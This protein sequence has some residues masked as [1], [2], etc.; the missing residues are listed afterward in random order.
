MSEQTY[1]LTIL[2]IAKIA[3]MDRIASGY[4]A[5]LANQ[6]ASFTRTLLT[7]QAMSELR[8]LMTPELMKP[9]MELMNSDLGFLTDKDPKRPRWNN[10]L[11]R[12]DEVKPYTEEV[13][14]DCL[15]SGTLQ[16]LSW[17]GNELNIISGKCYT[18]KNGLT[19]LLKKLKGLQNLVIS[20]GIPRLM[21]GGAI[22]PVSASWIY[23]GVKGSLVGMEG[24]S[25]IEIP[26]RVN[27]QMGSDAI[28]GKA[29]RKAKARIYAQI[30]GS[31]VAD[32]EIEADVLT[33]AKTVGA[34]V[35]SAPAGSVLDAIGP[36]GHLNA[37]DTLKNLGTL[38]KPVQGE[39]LPT[40]ADSG[41]GVGY[42]VVDEA[43]G[44]PVAEPQHSTSEASTPAAEEQHAPAAQASPE[45]VP[46]AAQ[47]LARE[48]MARLQ[49]ESLSAARFMEWAIR[50]GFAKDGAQSP[51]DIAE[52]DCQ[53]ILNGWKA[54][55]GLCSKTATAAKKG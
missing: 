1:E 23:N 3:A 51:L 7:A 36:G 49:K 17:V 14:R 15:I 34:G 29:E 21:A 9:V 44:A 8:A 41:D 35:G 24:R 47:S 12:Y 19:A 53:R 31:E 42:T 37:E 54:V 16:G 43:T 2:P 27:D 40:P 30:T 11:G 13:V 39:P 10:K 50:G 46:Q 48:I 28:L 26:V 5:A 4:Q 38:A 6:S 32:G 45:V 25:F 20:F 55:A 33:N 18:T 52:K 22:V